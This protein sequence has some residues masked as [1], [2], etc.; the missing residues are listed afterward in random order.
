[1]R[2]TATKAGVKLEIKGAT[3]GDLEHLRAEM[4]KLPKE[5]QVR[6]ATTAK[7]GGFDKAMGQAT[8]FQ[9]QIA[10]ITRSTKD[11]VTVKIKGVTDATQITALKTDM[12]RLTT[13]D[14][15]KVSLIAETRGLE[16]ARQAIDDIRRSYGRISDSAPIN[17]KATVQGGAEK[18]LTVLDQ[19]A[20][21]LDG[22][23][24][25][26]TTSAPDAY[27]TMVEIDGI[28]YKVD[29]L[30]GQSVLIPL[31][32][33]NTDGT[34]DGLKKTDA[35]VQELDGKS[36]TVKLNLPN[37][38]D[39]EG[40]LNRVGKAADRLNG[41]HA[42]VH[43]SAPS[44][45]HTTSLLGRIMSAAGRVSAKR[46]MVR[47]SAPGATQAHGL[48][49]RVRSM[50]SQVAGKHPRVVT[51]A[52]GATQA[53]GLVRAVGKAADWVN[54]KHARVTASANTGSA[55]SALNALT[56]PLRTTV[57]AVVHTVG[58][59]ASAVKGLFHANGGLYERHDPQ[60]A[61]AGAYR[62]WA[63]PE[64]EGEAYIPFARSKRGRSR[65]IAAQ[66]VQRL[67]GS[68]Q[69]FANGGITGAQAR[70]ILNIEARPTGELADYVQAVR[71][72][73][74]ATRARQR[75]SRAWWNAR[76]RHSK[77]E[78]KLGEALSKAKEK[79]RDA[80]EKA[81]QAADAL[82]RSAAQA[83]D[84]MAKDYRAG[85]SWQDWATS[86]REGVKELGL[87]RWRLAKLRGMGLSQENVDTIAG[88]GPAG[89]QLAGDVLAGGKTAVNSLNAAS[90]QLKKVS[91]QL[92]L[93]TMT[94]YA[95]GG[96]SSGRGIRVWSEPET[97]GEAY[98]PLAS[99]KR[100]RST[101]LWWETGRRLGAIPA[102]GQPRPI[103]PPAGTRSGYTP[104]PV[105]LSGLHITLSVPGL[106][107]AVDAKI[108]AANRATARNLVRSR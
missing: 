104:G 5:K 71:D 36:A 59:V 18:Q 38:G 28:K 65:M 37:T 78:K 39:T 97:G 15:K 43:T 50:A 81:R 92:G 70:M 86:M 49:N 98:I 42:T 62:G 89:V 72:A 99:G 17:M 106:A 76:R 11:G 22:K 79:E 95:D 9:Q 13:Q 46:A 10:G 51:S 25:L 40:K 20:T 19:H 8:Q 103:T 54:G 80:T 88:M 107:N 68:V 73:A 2:T 58:N 64:T 55:R 29:E 4:D 96:F 32:L 74:N 45:G 93:V 44:A 6:I 63:E 47:T 27:G 26:V 66:A 105:D 91:D 75:A 56:R 35:K 7:T 101:Q 102:T 69:W 77:S 84:T 87:F 34:Y 94:K 30:E 41:K 57:T 21:D 85:G 48:L 61:K 108:V 100:S 82:A 83:G 53:T 52:P 60:I 90:N 14:Q 24:V 23:N 1:V 3:T 33:K 12:E 67:G 16:P 31:G